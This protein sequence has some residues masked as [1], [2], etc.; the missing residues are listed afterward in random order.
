LVGELTN[1]KDRL[2]VIR[3][4]AKRLSKEQQGQSYHPDKHVPVL[5]ADDNYQEL[6][7]RSY[8]LDYVFHDDDPVE[9]SS[10]YSTVSAPIYRGREI[11]SGTKDNNTAM[12]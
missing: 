7:I 10:S 4:R 11:P 1:L 8:D 6:I 12:V 5:E 9:I 3:R 2:N